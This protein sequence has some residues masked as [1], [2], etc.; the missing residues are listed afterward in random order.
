MHEL[1]WTLFSC[2]YNKSST[3]KIRYHILQHTKEHAKLPVFIIKI[4]CI[5]FFKGLVTLPIKYIFL[6]AWWRQMLGL[7]TSLTEAIKKNE[8]FQKA[9][10]KKDLDIE[11]RDNQ[12]CNDESRS[13]S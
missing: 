4:R 5:Y 2:I 3:H 12:H 8:R 10:S 13:I 11:Q 9:L 1:Y 6:F 7:Q